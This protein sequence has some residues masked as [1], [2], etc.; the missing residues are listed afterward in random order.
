M[1]KSAVRDDISEWLSA[2]KEKDVSD[3]LIIVV[4]SEDV[5]VKSKLL[6]NSVFD[7]IKNDFCGRFP[8]R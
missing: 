2:L 3:W 1:Y 4:V 6:R 5:R 8:E 7:K